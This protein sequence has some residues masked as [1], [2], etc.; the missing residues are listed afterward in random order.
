MCFGK[1]MQFEIENILNLAAYFIRP[2]I[3]VLILNHNKPGRQ[4]IRLD[5]VLIIPIIITD[6][7]SYILFNEGNS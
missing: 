1:L 3:R 7:T 6:R 2:D 4:V 5:L